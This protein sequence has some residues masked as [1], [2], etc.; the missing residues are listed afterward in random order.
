MSDNL[1]AANKTNWLCRGH[2]NI[3]MSSLIEH[4]RFDWFTITYAFF[5]ERLCLVANLFV[6]VDLFVGHFLIYFFFFF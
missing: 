4:F 2:S 5:R 3:S 1:F 6:S